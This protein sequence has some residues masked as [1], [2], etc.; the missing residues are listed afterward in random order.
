LPGSD[1]KSARDSSLRD[2]RLTGEYRRILRHQDR[3]DRRPALG[4]RLECQPHVPVGVIEVR[5][6]RAFL[7]QLIEQRIERDA[8]RDEDPSRRVVS[9]DSV[10]FAISRVSTTMHSVRSISPSRDPDARTVVAALAATPSTH[11]AATASI[12]DSGLFSV[13]VWGSGFRFVRFDIVSSP[14]TK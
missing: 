4:L 3:L 13:S 7:V 11:M 2:V 1:V 9:F 5:R 8:L 10:A 12:G 6:I 14:Q